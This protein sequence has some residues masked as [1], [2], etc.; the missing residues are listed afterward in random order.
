ML[1]YFE[2]KCSHVILI[3]LCRRKKE[4]KFW[5]AFDAN[6]LSG[7]SITIKIVQALPGDGIS[8]LVNSELVFFKV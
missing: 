6:D 2:K 4:F 8:I 1:F 5:S 3:G 7:R